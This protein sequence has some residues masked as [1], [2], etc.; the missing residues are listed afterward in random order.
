MVRSDI[1]CIMSL[2]G[3][4][5]AREY[6]KYVSRIYDFLMWQFS[7][8]HIQMGSH[9][10]QSFVEW[11]CKR[12]CKLVGPRLIIEYPVLGW[13]IVFAQHEITVP[14]TGWIT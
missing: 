1:H 2:H 14:V 5:D 6:I 11:N 12:E 9:Q 13:F 8:S 4:F 7:V 10:L 3:L